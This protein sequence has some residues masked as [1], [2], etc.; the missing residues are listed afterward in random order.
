M[1]QLLAKHSAG[2][3]SRISKMNTQTHGL[4]L[5]ITLHYIAIYLFSVV[6]FYVFPL[7][8]LSLVNFSLFLSPSTEAVS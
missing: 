1:S 8:Y 7:N 4:K 5:G 3:E 2:I 6:L